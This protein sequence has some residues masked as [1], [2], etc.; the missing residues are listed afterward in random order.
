MYGCCDAEWQYI[1]P[2]FPAESAISTLLFEI[3]CD[4][5]QKPTPVDHCKYFTQLALP[6]LDFKLYYLC[7]MNVR[8]SYMHDSCM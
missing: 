1:V 2:I 5:P 8:D 7:V 3:G 4:V 6:A